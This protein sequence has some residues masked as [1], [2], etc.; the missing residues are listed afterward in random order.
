MQEARQKE[1][2]YFERH[3][4]YSSLAPNMGTSHLVKRLSR[5]LMV[6]IQR[7]L[8]GFGS[9]VQALIARQEEDLRSLPETT[10]LETMRIHFQVG[11]PSTTTY[12]WERRC[13]AKFLT[14]QKRQNFR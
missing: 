4:A 9:K 11:A 10:T 8:P 7:E 12:L 2:D 1:A 14:N 13:L 5:L 6:A 3:P